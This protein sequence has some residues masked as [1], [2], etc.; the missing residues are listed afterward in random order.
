MIVAVIVI[1]IVVLSSALIIGL[2][3][4]WRNRNIERSKQM[5]VIS[6]SK[7][8]MALK[9]LNSQTTTNNLKYI[10]DYTVF[11]EAKRNLTILIFIDMFLR[12]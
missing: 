8:I 11:Y 3:V 9:E 2:L 6:K 1:I 12:M 7:K 10:Y 5:Y 4:F